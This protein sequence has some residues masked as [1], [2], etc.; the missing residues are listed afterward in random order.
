MKCIKPV[1]FPTLCVDEGV[2]ESWKPMHQLIYKRMCRHTR[3]ITGERKTTL[4]SQNYAPVVTLCLKANT[5]TPKG[6]NL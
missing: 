5:L 2:A 3:T 6:N 1:S 4:F